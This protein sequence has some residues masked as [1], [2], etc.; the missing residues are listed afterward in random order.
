VIF[1]K[2]RLPGAYVIRLEKHED[3]RGFF[4]RAWCSR[5]FEDRNL[6]TRAAQAN[7]SL[8]RYEGTL[9]GMH[10]QIPPAAETKI[11]RCTRG[12]IYDVI[13]D[14][15]PDSPTS[16]EWVGV[17]LAADN[18]TMLYVPEGFAHGFQ[19]LTDDAEVYYQVSEFYSPTHERGVRYN[20]PAFRIEWPRSVTCISEKD[21]KW[22]DYVAEPA[23]FGGG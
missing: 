15:R 9:R 14:L 4:A 23:A 8:S 21:R 3:S 22:P 5:E 11:V 12:T 13:L 10:Y 7:I 2:T 20:D 17:E 6:I 16:G 18:Y 1:E 19:T